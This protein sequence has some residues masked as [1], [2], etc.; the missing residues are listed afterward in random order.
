MAA[1]IGV[2]PFK[3]VFWTSRSNPGN[4]YYYNCMEVNLEA[5]P[6]V[7]W[8]LN[9]RYVG[10]INVTETGKPCLPW[11]DLNLIWEYPLGDLMRSACRNPVGLLDGDGRPFCYYEAD[12]NTPRSEWKWENCA[13]PVC[14]VDCTRDQ[15]LVNS[16]M[17]YCEELIEPNPSLQAVVSTLSLAGVAFGDEVNNVDKNVLARTMREDG[18]ILTVDYPARAAPIQIL[19]MAFGG[20]HQVQDP[21]A[22]DVGEIWSS[23][24]RVGGL[25]FGL[26]LV[27]GNQI[28]R[29]IVI[30]ELGLNLE[31]DTVYLMTAFYDPTLVHRVTM[32]SLITLPIMDEF[33]F[34]LYY[35]SPVL[36]TFEYQVAFVG[37]STK[38]VPFSSSRYNEVRLEPSNQLTVTSQGGVGSQ[39]YVSTDGFNFEAISMTCSGTLDQTVV[40]S[41]DLVTMDQTCA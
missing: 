9:Y 6:N 41:I 35:F 3:D 27:V 5:D 7:P 18:R 16:S 10:P 20:I 12:L 29:S 23:N 17:P 11:A 33:E 36:S 40:A 38:F 2:K 8:P 22:L 31:P 19:E 4:P 39:V 14:E 13:I 34:E 15:A 21:I 30:S 37:D 32:E 26:T 25:D 24:S 1:A 28:G